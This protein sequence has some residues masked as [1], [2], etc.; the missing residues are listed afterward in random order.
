MGTIYDL[1]TY[2][3]LANMKTTVASPWFMVALLNLLMN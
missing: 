3:K 1:K 2:E